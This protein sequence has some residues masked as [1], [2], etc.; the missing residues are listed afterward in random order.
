M[1]NKIV[2]TTFTGNSFELYISPK[3]I[4]ISKSNAF[5]K[6]VKEI[7]PIFLNNTL[8]RRDII[9]IGR[10]PRSLYSPKPIIMVVIPILMAFLV[11]L[12]L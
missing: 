12:A 3:N 6:F 7:Q 10:I 9:L 8:A 11:F 2:S 4:W 5:C 1:K